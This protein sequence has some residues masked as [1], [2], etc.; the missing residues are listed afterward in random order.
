MEITNQWD[1]L[2]WG[3]V[4]ITGT[5]MTYAGFDAVFTPVVSPNNLDINELQAVQ[6]IS[7]YDAGNSDFDIKDTAQAILSA[8]DP[9]LL[10]SGVDLITVNDGPTSASEG[11]AITDLSAVVEFDVADTAENVISEMVGT[12]SSVFDEADSVAY[13]GRCYS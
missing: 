10:D 4:N 13:I 1:G 3:V 9:V 7:G 8:G 12:G 2:G 11:I 6:A 5:T